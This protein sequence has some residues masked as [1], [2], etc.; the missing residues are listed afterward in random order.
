MRSTA[1]IIPHPNFSQVFSGDGSGNAFAIVVHALLLRL[2]LKSCEKSGLGETKNLFFSNP[3]PPLVRRGGWIV[4]G[5][6]TFTALER[7]RRF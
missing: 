7:D 5:N 4:V 1:D 2:T 6:P 3:Q